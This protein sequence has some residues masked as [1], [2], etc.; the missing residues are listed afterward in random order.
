MQTVRFDVANPTAR[1][2]I[3]NRKPYGKQTD[4]L[5]QEAAIINSYFENGIFDVCGEGHKPTTHL[6]QV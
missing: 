1:T 5:P 2:K 4:W 3:C 6:N